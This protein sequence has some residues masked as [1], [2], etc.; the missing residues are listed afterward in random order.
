MYLLEN[1]LDCFY[2]FPCRVVYQHF[3]LLSLSKG[4]L[5]LICFALKS[6]FFLKYMKI[7]GFQ[8][9][10]MCLG[11]LFQHFLV[12]Y[13]LLRS[14]ICCI[15]L[16]LEN[17]WSLSHQIFLLPFFLLFCQLHIDCLILVLQLLSFFC[18]FF[19]LF[20][21]VFSLGNFYLQVH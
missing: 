21:G 12:I 5:Y 16:M 10:V 7:F 14:V 8:H 1:K 19:H 3:F 17:F 13:R 6:D 15:S 11:V 2:D 20:L 18:S 4:H 9:F